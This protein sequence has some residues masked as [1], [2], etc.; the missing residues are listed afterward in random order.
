MGGGAVL[1]VAGWMEKLGGGLILDYLRKI[2]N[3]EETLEYFS[4]SR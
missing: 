1:S 3:L 4:R 2:P